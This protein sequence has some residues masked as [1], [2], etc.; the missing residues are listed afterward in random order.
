MRAALFPCFDEPAF[1]ARWAL[2]VQVPAGPGGA[3]QRRACSRTSV[4]GARRK[5][6][7]QETRASSPRTSSRSWWARW[8]ARP[9]GDGGGVPV[10]TWASPEKAHL[11][12]SGRRRRW[13]CCRGSRTTSG[14][15]TP[16]GKLDQVGIPDFEAGRDGERGPH[17]LP[18]GGAAARP[19]APRR[20]RCRSA[21]P[22]SS[23][24]SSRTSGSATGSRWCG[25]TTSGSTRPSPPGWPTRSS[26]AG[27]P[28]WRVWLDFDAGKAAALH[29]DALRVHAPHPRRG[30]Q[31]RRGHRELRRHHLREG[32]RGA[33]DDRGLPRRGAVP[34][35][36]SATYM[37]KHARGNAVADDLWGALARGLARSRWSSWP[38]RGSARAA[39]R[40]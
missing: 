8:W 30:A 17:H 38:T 15:P 19:G 39:I 22:R 2:T 18:R 33:A 3:G 6:T 36:A 40:W 10:R 31:R 13:R 24:T 29:L 12:A 20:W 21:W 7:F 35:R 32:R 9:R 26:T 34:R 1:K 27:G 16:F 28:T 23:P 4:E 37:R 11:R 5:V 14:C 25:G